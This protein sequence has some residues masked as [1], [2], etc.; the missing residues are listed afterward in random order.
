MVVRK[1]I[2]YVFRIQRKVTRDCGECTAC[3]EGHLAG[4]IYGHV[5][6]PGTPCHFLGENRCS[7]YQKRPQNPCKNFTCAW[8]VDE[9]RVLPEWM[10]P[11]LSK[12]IVLEKEW[13][14][15]KYWKVL[16]AGQKMNVEILNWL[17]QHCIDNELCLHYEVAGSMYTIGPQAFH[18]EVNNDNA[19]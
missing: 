5:M 16:E 14:G 8:L 3:C 18:R 10:K 15:G 19:S 13:T 1:D 17:I 9:G 4:T 11:S 12:V 7:I 6:K 2:D